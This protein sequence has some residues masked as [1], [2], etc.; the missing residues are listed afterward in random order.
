M[1]LLALGEEGEDQVGKM[2]SFVVTSGEV[3][4]LCANGA[5]MQ[6]HDI[7]HILL[8]GEKRDIIYGSCTWAL[9]KCGASNRTVSSRCVG[10]R[11]T[12]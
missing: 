2:A 11:T 12:H 4:M 7:S 10:D 5:T 8:Y 1:A 6:P 9:D 3:V